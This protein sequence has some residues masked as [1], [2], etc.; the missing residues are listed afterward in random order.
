MLLQLRVLGIAIAALV[1][2]WLLML[3]L[4]WIGAATKDITPIVG[5]GTQQY[6]NALTIGAV[7]ALIALGYT[8]VYGIIEL[9]NFAHGDVFM[10]GAFLSL[11]VMTSLGFHGAISNPLLLVGVLVLVFVVTMVVMGLLGVGI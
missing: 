3:A 5:T 2:G 11:F 10:V 4:V 7:Y 9:I 8:M 6:L 1:V